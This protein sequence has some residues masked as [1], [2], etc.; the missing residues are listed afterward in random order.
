MKKLFFVLL[1]LSVALGV[2]ACNSLNPTEPGLHAAFSWSNDG[3][4]VQ[5]LDQTTPD[6]KSWRWTFGD[7]TSSSHQQDP[8][9]EYSSEGQYRV[10]LRACSKDGL[11]G[12]C[13]DSSGFVTV[14]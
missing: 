5:F 1:I 9:H 13:S 4:L 6:A 7:A 2:S 11:N 12:K 8:V 3:L 14:P 10:D